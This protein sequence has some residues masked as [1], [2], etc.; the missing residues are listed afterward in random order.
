MQEETFPD[1]NAFP[2]LQ[3]IWESWFLGKLAW[4]TAHG[5]LGH[6]GVFWVSGQAVGTSFHQK[7]LQRGKNITTWCTRMKQWWNPF[8]CLHPAHASTQVLR[9]IKRLGGGGGTAGQEGFFADGE[10]KK[11]TEPI[12]PSRS[13]PTLQ[14]YIFS[15]LENNNP[16]IQPVWDHQSLIIDFRP[17]MEGWE[18]VG[19]WKM[20]ARTMSEF[21]DILQQQ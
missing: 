21:C 16:F 13:E 20:M 1:L 14:T 10:G 11:T 2:R 7:L 19:S 5:R 3:I 17:W 4:H 15:I 18:G 6:T 8:P 9:E 12:F